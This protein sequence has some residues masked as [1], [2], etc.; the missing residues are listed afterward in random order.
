MLLFNEYFYVPRKGKMSEMEDDITTMVMLSLAVVDRP[1]VLGLDQRQY[2]GVAVGLWSWHFKP[3]VR[4]AV[5]RDRKRSTKKANSIF[6]KRTLLIESRRL[7]AAT[8]AASGWNLHSFLSN[9]N[10]C[11]WLIV[12]FVRSNQASN[13]SGCHH[14]VL[15]MLLSC[16]RA[17]CV[18]GA[19]AQC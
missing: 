19:S 9:E 18:L 2:E 5:D 16:G 4:A 14:G 7:V 13:S 15:V 6:Q 10:F 17:V 11:L 8:A 12:C 3:F 1:L